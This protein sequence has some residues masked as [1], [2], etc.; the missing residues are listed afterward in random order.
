MDTVMAIYI[1]AAIGGAAVIFVLLLVAFVFVRYSSFGRQEH[2]STKITPLSDHQLQK[3]TKS[4]LVEFAQ[5]HGVHLNMRSTKANMI[6]ELKQQ[7]NA[8]K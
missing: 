4:Q 7:L 8:K 5:Q 6:A 3:N 1:L 2:A